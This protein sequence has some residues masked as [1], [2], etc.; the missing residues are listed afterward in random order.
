MYKE[1][2]N[3]DS[4]VN[5]SYI[6]DAKKKYKKDERKWIF[7]LESYHIIRKIL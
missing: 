6:I 4:Y 5:T 3:T 2:F 7:H 1:G